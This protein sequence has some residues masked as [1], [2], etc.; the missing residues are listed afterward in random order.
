MAE[1]RL[2][3]HARICLSNA[4]AIV[5][6]NIFAVVVC[7]YVYSFMRFNLHLYVYFCYGHRTC[8]EQNET[9]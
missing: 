7:V 1:S 6:T 5:K 3:S 8:T 2:R 9:K 4:E